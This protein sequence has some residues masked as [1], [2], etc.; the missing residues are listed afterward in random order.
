MP[1]KYARCDKT[2]N[3]FRVDV[4]EQKNRGAIIL[5]NLNANF[6]VITNCFYY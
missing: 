4:H 3:L 5:E 1:Y 2:K 6:I